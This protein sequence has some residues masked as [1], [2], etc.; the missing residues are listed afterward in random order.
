MKLTY[1]FSQKTKTGLVVL[2]MLG[3]MSGCQKED[4]VVSS[5]TKTQTEEITSEEAV[6]DDIFEDTDEISLEAIVVAENG[7]LQADS[8][9]R[10]ACTSY[11]VERSGNYSKT[12]TLTFEEGCAGTIGRE[13]SGVIIVNRAIDSED[14]TYTVT[15]TFQNFSIN[16]KKIEGTRTMVF[17]AEDNALASITVILTGGKV[18]LEDGK[19]ITRSGAFTKTI[20]RKT[21]EISLEGSAQGITRAGVAYTAAIVEPVVYKRSCAGEGV[22]MAVQGK[23]SITREGK[24]DFTVDYGTGT[25]DKLVTVNAEGKSYAVEVNIT[26]K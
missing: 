2:A 17:A 23:K 1:V 18:T 10:S 7:R 19:V 14:S 8:V 9:V 6:A 13:R 5:S 15:T 16:G 24:F 21:G 11:T 12:V 3:C 20:D 26:K 25:C 22:F 4:E